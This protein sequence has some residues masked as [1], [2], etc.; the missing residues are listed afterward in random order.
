MSILWTL[1]EWVFYL[2]LIFLTLLILPNISPLKWQEFFKSSIA[3]RFSQ[4]INLYFNLIIIALVL[5]ITDDNPGDSSH[6]SRN[7]DRQNPVNLNILMRF[8]TQYKYFMSGSVLILWFV[9]K[10]LIMLIQNLNELIHENEAIKRQAESFVNTANNL[11]EES[12]NDNADSIE[13]EKELMRNKD[14]I[15]RLNKELSIA[16]LDLEASKFKF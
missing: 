4:N 15:K 14:E 8:I 1:I 12:K 16:K 13:M 2:E 5:L 11:L 7:C 9:V 6:K 3:L 10:R